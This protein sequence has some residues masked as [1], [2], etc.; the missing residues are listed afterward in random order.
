MM[1]ARDHDEFRFSGTVDDGVGELPCHD[2]ST[3]TFNASITERISKDSCD[4]RLNSKS[5]LES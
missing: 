5:K 4:C 3:F 1:K 2:M